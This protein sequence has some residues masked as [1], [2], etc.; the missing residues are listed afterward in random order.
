MLIRR[1]APGPQVGRAAA[2]R[3]DRGGRRGRDVRAASAAVAPRAGRAR[4]AKRS[5]C[6]RPARP[7][8]AARP[9]RGAERGLGGANSRPDPL[10]VS[11]GT[12]VTS[13][14]RSTAT[15]RVAR[16][17]RRSR[18][19]A[20]GTSPRRS[21]RRPRTAR[22]IPSASAASVPGSGRGARPPPAPFGCGTGPP[23]PAWRRAPRLQQQPPQVGR[24][25]HRVPAPE[26]HVARMR[27]PS[28]STSGDRP[29]VAV[30]PRCRRSRR[31]CA[32]ARSRPS[33]FITRALI[34]SPWTSP[35]VP[36]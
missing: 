19:R 5:C 24:R 7:R 21:A 30:R 26:Q 9:R 10:D 14:A 17:A 1:T 2:G 11:A 33:A 15:R 29:C 28:G 34:R 4:G 6:T 31:S 13:A 35:C 36:M 8:A 27:P 32:R 20:R 16:A 23:R 25:R 18:S 3:G 12:P 22:I